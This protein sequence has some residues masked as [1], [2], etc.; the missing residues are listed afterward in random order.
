MSFCNLKSPWAFSS[1]PVPIFNLSLGIIDSASGISL[2]SVFY[3]LLPLLL[4]RLLFPLAKRCFSPEFPHIV[5]RIISHMRYSQNQ[6]MTPHCLQNK[7][8]ISGCALSTSLPWLSILAFHFNP[9]LHQIK[10]HRTSQPS[11]ILTVASTIPRW[12]C[13]HTGAFTGI[14][15]PSFPLI[16]SHLHLWKFY[17]LSVLNLVL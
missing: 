11:L 5:V 13:H 4:L 6:P 14:S 2:K 17:S 9:H 12:A 7:V 3:S 15:A 10:S 16:I 8:Q 1:C